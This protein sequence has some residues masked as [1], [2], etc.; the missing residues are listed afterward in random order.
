[1][2]ADCAGRVEAVIGRPLPL[3]AFFDRLTPAL[4]AE[5]IPI[6]RVDLRGEVAAE[7]RWW[8]A[9][10]AEAEPLELPLDHAR[11]GAGERGARVAFTS[12]TR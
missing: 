3:S 6:E 5:Q 2:P 12:T 10:L 7:R 4:L 1:M 8:R 11:Q 9:Q